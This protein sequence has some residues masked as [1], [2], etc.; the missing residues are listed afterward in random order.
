MHRYVSNEADAIRRFIST[1]NLGIRYYS[2]SKEQASLCRQADLN[3][4][5]CLGINYATIN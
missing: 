5:Y 2:L 1:N 3:E 4:K